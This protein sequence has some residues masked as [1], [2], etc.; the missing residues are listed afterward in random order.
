MI[1]LTPLPILPPDESPGDAHSPTTIAH[2]ASANPSSVAGWRTFAKS[3]YEAGAAAAHE[4]TADEYGDGV[5]GVSGRACTGSAS[6]NSVGVV[7]F[8]VHSSGRRRHDGCRWRRGASVPLAAGGTAVGDLATAPVP[9]RA[10][11]TPPAARPPTATP[12]TARGSSSGPGSEM[13]CR[14]GPKRRDGS[15]LAIERHARMRGVA[16]RTKRGGHPTLHS[17]SPARASD[18]VRVD[19]DEPATDGCLVAVRDLARGRETVIRLLIERDGRRVLPPPA[20]TTFNLRLRPTPVRHR[21]SKTAGG[22]PCRLPRSGPWDADSGGRRNAFE[23]EKMG[24]Y[25]DN[26]TIFAAAPCCRIALRQSDLRRVVG[27]G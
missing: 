25:I 26:L 11:A 19:P 18:Y 16:P 4:R 1:I 2:S 5:A 17:A 21:S 15:G 13:G 8:A 20:P 9:P 27:L 23:G 24:G 3:A 22:R 6:G 7:T 12:N 14:D 10:Q